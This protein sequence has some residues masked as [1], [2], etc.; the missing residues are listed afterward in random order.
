MDCSSSSRTAAALI[1]VGT[2]SSKRSRP[3][4]TKLA[5]CTEV[6]RCCLSPIGDLLQLLENILPPQ[7]RGLIL[8]AGIGGEL[9]RELDD[10]PAV[11]H[12]FEDRP[13]RRRVAVARGVRLAPGGVVDRPGADLARQVRRPRIEDQQL[14]SQLRHRRGWTT[15]GKES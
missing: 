5:I 8:H 12:R 6:S 10:A 9:L 3:S 11:L 7:I 1:A 4:A 2:S 15:T 14:L 13:V